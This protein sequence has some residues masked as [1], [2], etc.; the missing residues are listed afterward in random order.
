MG[1]PPIGGNSFFGMSATGYIAA[2]NFDPGIQVFGSSP[3]SYGL[4]IN[5]ANTQLYLLGPA[6]FIVPEPGT[7]TLLTLGSAMLLIRR[8]KK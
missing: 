2:G 4:P 5:S 1:G 7:W 6:S 8:R 3:A